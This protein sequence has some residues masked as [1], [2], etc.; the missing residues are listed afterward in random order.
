MIDLV[1]V[2]RD[3]KGSAKWLEPALERVRNM[4]ARWGTNA[5]A[6]VNEVWKMFAANSPAFGLWVGIKDDQI[7]GHAL[8]DIRPY[9]GEWRVWVL[10]VETDI[11]VG[12]AYRDFVQKTIDDWG[13]GAAKALNLTVG[14]SLMSTP[15]IND[16]W[17][18]HSGYEVYRVIHRRRIP[19]RAE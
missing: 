5:D 11:V 10:Q 2:S 15:R 16:A 14:D 6:M 4:A 7:V 3:H 1:Q 12:R 17:A 13:L 19:K 8:A 9:D 18:R